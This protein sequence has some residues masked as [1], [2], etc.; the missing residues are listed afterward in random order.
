[1]LLTTFATH[2]GPKGINCSAKTLTGGLL[3][4]KQPLGA[5]GVSAAAVSVSMLIDASLIMPPNFQAHRAIQSYETG[6]YVAPEDFTEEFWLGS[7]ERYIMEARELSDTKWLKI[8]HAVEP[9]VEK[10][11][12]TTKKGKKRASRAD[13]EGR[14]PPQATMPRSSPIP[15]L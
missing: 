5:L 7:T 1:M 14:L 13:L 10:Q 15:E 9:F 12:A 8:L 2:F 4:G 11:A 6:V 3:L